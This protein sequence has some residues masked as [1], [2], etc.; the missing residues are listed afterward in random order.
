MVN[1]AADKLDVE[2]GWNISPSGN[3][4][5]DSVRDSTALDMVQEMIQSE[6]LLLTWPSMSLIMLTTVLRAE[7]SIISPSSAMIF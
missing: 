4:D 5:S 2:C 6:M 7:P 3:F 1:I